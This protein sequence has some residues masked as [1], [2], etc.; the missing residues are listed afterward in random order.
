MREAAAAAAHLM[1]QVDA[2]GDK[3][4]SFDEVRSSDKESLFEKLAT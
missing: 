2:N 1:S 3:R 4:L